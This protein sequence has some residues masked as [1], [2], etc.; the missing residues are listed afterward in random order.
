MLLLG[1]TALATT[2]NVGTS[3]GAAQTVNVGSTMT[4]SATS[5]N[6]GNG[7]ITIQT[8]DNA[9]GDTGSLIIQSEVLPAEHLAIFQLIMA[10]APTVAARVL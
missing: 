5:L 4:T 1:T 7:G 8:G 2:V 9:S 10:P 6:G 3:T